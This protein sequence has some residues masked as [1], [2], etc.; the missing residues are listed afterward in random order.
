MRNR[1]YV[2]PFYSIVLKILAF[3]SLLLAFIFEGLMIY[4]W[5]RLNAFYDILRNAW[6]AILMSLQEIE[7][8]SLPIGELPSIPTWP[9][10]LLLFL[11]LVGGVF[12]ALTLLAI[13]HWIDFR[14]SVAEE[15][16]QIRALQ[17]KT[18]NTIAH[19]IASVAGYF[20]SLPAPRGK[21]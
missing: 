1:F 2:L 14:L 10:L 20:A 7:G 8:S 19:D 11:I 6:Q 16:S 5:S 4:F 3:V 12:I 15:E 9:L 18:L 13:S 21:T 17:I